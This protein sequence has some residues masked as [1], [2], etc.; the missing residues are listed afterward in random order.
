MS[1]RQ[2]LFKEEAQ[3]KIARGV[4]IMA[5]AV[6]A[7]MGVKGHTVMFES[8]DSKPI[9]SC[10]GV[11]VARNIELEDP[12]EKLGADAVK[13]AS[14]KT[15]DVAG[16]GTTTAA[17]LARAIYK[18]GR[19]R[20]TN[21]ANPTDIKAQI[22]HETLEAIRSLTSMAVPA[23]TTEM[24]ER[25]ATISSKDASLGKL[26]SG[27]VAEVG[28]DGLV[29]IEVG[30]SL[31][32]ETEIT[33]GMKLDTGFVQPWMV[34]N[35]A[36]MSTQLDECPVM[37][38]DATIGAELA[39]VM[40]ELAKKGQKKLFI[41]AD[42]FTNE[43]LALMYTN[44]A[45]GKF[46]TVGIRASGIGDKRKVEGLLDICAATGATL[47]S[48]TT[49]RTVKDA[50]P[51]LLG[52]ARQ[53]TVNAEST[54]IVEGAGKQEEVDKR[55]AVIRKEHEETKSDYDK[56]KLKERLARLTGSA[57]IIK[58]GGINEAEIKERKDRV[59]DA[60]NAVRAAQAEGIIVGGGTSLLNASVGLDLL[61]EPLRA[62]LRTIAEN[63]GKSS[64]VVLEKCLTM[65]VGGY[66]AAT[67]TYEDLMAVG[68]IDPLRV[69]RTA[70]ENAAAVAGLLLLTEVAI[71]T[72]RENKA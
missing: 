42:G 13:E 71:V 63:A 72:K 10:D 55:I 61:K 50:K 25:V 58:V 2:I 52:T 11:T 23:D 54:L 40:N 1:T 12:F 28:K 45:Q 17:V 64:D 31:A 37:V 22:E 24:L 7:T 48:E 57:G 60:V 53:I 39:N 67:D 68:V 3:A 27:L 32:V 9:F 6:G 21:G 26:I 69:T 62:P 35:P 46:V 16:D 33:R 51:E 49:G 4:D 15:N 47:I 34:T 70:L 43:A 18:E 36:K 14:A 20:I 5:D 65:T 30:P 41:V 44:G 56:V 38:T 59:E 66:N 19:R 8:Y 29:T